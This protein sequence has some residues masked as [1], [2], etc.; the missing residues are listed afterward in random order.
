MWKAT[1]RELIRGCLDKESQR[2]A[3]QILQGQKYMKGGQPTAAQCEH[4]PF[5]GKSKM[6]PEDDFLSK[7]SLKNSRRKPRVGV[8]GLLS[9][10]LLSALLLIFYAIPFPSSSPLVH[11][12]LHTL[13][14]N[15][16][17]APAAWR[18]DEVPDAQP[19]DWIL[20]G[21]TQHT[22]R[23]LEQISRN[24]T[25]PCHNLTTVRT[26]IVGLPDDRPVRILTDEVFRFKLV[27]VGEDGK[28][29]CAGGDYYEVDLAGDHWRSR[30]QVT[31][32]DDGSYEVKV[33]V[34]G[35]KPGLYNFTARLLFA[36]MHGLDH[37][38]L[39]W[40]L[41]G[42]VAAAV[43]ILAV[44]KQERSGAHGVNTDTSTRKISSEMKPCTGAEMMSAGSGGGRWTRGAFN[45]SCT[46]NKD[47]GRWQCLSGE[48]AQCEAPWCDGEVAALESNGW[49]YSD[50]SCGFHIFTTEEAWDC[51]SGR[52]MFMWG[53][54][55]MLDFLRNLLV[56]GLEYPPP[57]WANI[58]TWEMNRVV[59]QPLFVNPRRPD[60]AVRVSYVFN[61]HYET[62]GDWLGLDSLQHSPYRD[63]LRQ[64][65]NG[66]AGH[67]DTFVFNTGLHDGLNFHT[68][69]EF[70]A[71]V[72]EGADFWASVFQP[73]T[74]AA[75]KRLRF[76]LRT[77]VAPAGP[78]RWNKSNPQKM[79]VYNAIL[80]EGF[81]KRFAGM[82]VIDAFDVTFPFHYDFSCSDGG[83]YGRPPGIR[84][85]P[86]FDTPH[87][88]YVEIM[89]VHMM[90]NSICSSPPSGS[91]A[92]IV[93]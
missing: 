74:V 22:K 12:H 17:C 36:N 18:D 44:R 49:V 75:R 71:A 78:A 23:I 37:E 76:L 84:R 51:L 53:D 79:E 58:S 34:D 6:L 42:E 83:H 9:L 48:A 50:R 85:W 21:R 90:L 91:T 81:R 14:S 47:D 92:Q 68:T 27:S 67:P 16:S 1:A 45:S 4:L 54:S 35:Q 87:H 82:H 2:K 3:D 43:Q 30:P 60:Q 55:N 40:R 86:W 88:Y 62:T 80:L 38:T 66:S 31:D 33:L 93:S 5:L 20:M 63:Q 64:F 89:L 24:G 28:V 8:Y 65:F 77:T 39:P 70:A 13:C 59:E 15:C 41:D 26:E 56:F 25:T 11:P 69:E 73:L 19:S 10:L 61:G 32:L 52:W 46:A 7:P 29:R 72:E 57:S